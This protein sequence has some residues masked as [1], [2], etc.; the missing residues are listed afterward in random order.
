MKSML[1]TRPC[2][3]S[4]SSRRFAWLLPVL[5][6]AASFAAVPSLGDDWPTHMHDNARGGVTP[7]PIQTPLTERWTRLS[8]AAPKPAWPLPQPGWTELPKTRF[9]DALYTVA[10]GTRVYFG[11]SV[12]HQVYALDAATGAVRWKFFTGG[13]VRLAPTIHAGRL[14]FGSDDG[15]VYCLRCD[16]GSVV[17]TFN[18]ATSATRV[19]GN[20][21]VTSLWPVRTSVMIEDGRAYFGA[22]VFPF[23]TVFLYALDAATGKE[24]WKRD[25]VTS[26]GGFSPQGYLLS[27]GPSLVVPA[28]RSAPCLVRRDNGASIDNTP[29]KLPKGEATGVYGVVVDK[30]LF[31]GTQNSLYATNLAGGGGAPPL[32][33]TLKLVA[34]QASYFTLRGPPTPAYGRR[35]IST[36]NNAI[37]CIDRSVYQQLPKKDSDSVSKARRWRYAAPGLSSMI[38]AGDALIAGADDKVVILGAADGKERWSAKVDGNA[39][40]LSYANGRLL[41]STTKGT[42]HCFSAEAGPAA[43]IQFGPT[44]ATDDK[45]AAIAAAALKA[46]DVTRGYAL[47]VGTG[48]EE[49]ACELARRSDLSIT[50]VELDPKRL[51]AARRH[52]DAAG[53]YGHRVTVQPGSADNFPFPDF[54]ANL[55]LQLD[56]PAQ[57]APSPREL[58]RALK[59]CGGVLLTSRAPT[60]DDLAAWKQAGTLTGGV[61]SAG[62]QTWTR[63]TRGELPG[64]GWWTHQFADAGGSG[65]SSDQLVRGGL[66]VLW[67]GEPGGDMMP[68]RH[69]RGSAPLMFNGR[70]YCQGWHFLEKKMAVFCFDAYNGLRYWEREIPG[71]PRLGLPS[72]ASNLAVG[73]EG[74]FVV[75]GDKCTRLDLRTGEV[76]STFDAPP[77][78]GGAATSPATGPA[79]AGR[80][81]GYV[82]LLDGALIGSAGKSQERPTFSDT[83]FAYDIKS[84][85]LHWRHDAREIRDSTIA[86]ANGRVYFADNARGQ[87][88]K[89]PAKVS[90]AVEADPGEGETDDNGN[91]MTDSTKASVKG[92][93]KEAAKKEPK[94]SAVDRLGAPLVPVEPVLRNIVALNAATGKPVWSREVDLLNCG[95]WSAGSFGTPQAICKDDVLI[96]AGAYTIYGGLKPDEPPHRV[97]ALSTRDGKELWSDSLMNRSRPI[98][99]R[100]ALLA[101][102]I[103]Y[104]PTTGKK[105]IKTQGKREGPW[106]IGPRTGGCGSLSASDF[107]VFGRGGI[108]QWRNVAGGPSGAFVG[109]RPGCFINIIPAGGVVVQV[110]ASSGCA[111]YQAIQCTVVFRPLPSAKP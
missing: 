50:C 52:V 64:S 84:Q 103:F 76:L 96:F 102:P 63:L 39:A 42:I 23:H 81:W 106:S 59:P 93:S 3:P 32:H 21:S 90:P 80:T 24:I 97:L 14:Y 107:M 74:L 41:V 40:G 4:H 15:Q 48:G 88:E 55:V 47:V 86:C 9:D 28:G 73:P 35:S 30:T 100:D 37:L 66:G 18:A 101:E 13:P 70:M 51:T 78:A 53:L 79:P 1:H 27:G 60:G 95:R 72:V 26:Y 45:A 44:P 12:D 54:A 5:L 69:Q 43:P 83:L 38:V 105:I 36:E 82:A 34:T 109:T 99:M 2:S 89:R 85:K 10:D 8:P 7:E 58:L 91:P 67:F 57:P 77:A 22:G 108:T 19:L 29:T 20:G 17:W 11:S 61:P 111:C 56:A 49:V 68:D 98:M 31:V 94:D 104:E 25:D 87:V 92:K 71:Q 16:D 110:E 33:D 65:S 62:P 6:V 75:A 46:S